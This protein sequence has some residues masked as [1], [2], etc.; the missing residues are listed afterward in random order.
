MS[1]STGIQGK[2]GNRGFTAIEITAV[3]TIIAILAMLII[4][5]L[6]ERVDETRETAALSDLK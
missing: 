2:A 1:L 5:L 4:P 6:R 3:A